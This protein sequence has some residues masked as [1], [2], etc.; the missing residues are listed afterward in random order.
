MHDFEAISVDVRET[1]LFARR[2]GEGPPLLLLHGFPQTHLMWRLVAP[3]L[4]RQF[5]V[6]CADLRGYGASG[7]PDSDGSHGPYAK[8]AMARD[9]VVLME[10]LGFVSFAVAG[11]DRGGR[12]AYRLAL[13]HPGRVTR[14]ALLDVL[15]TSTVWE[16]ADARF[17]LA[18]WPWSM[19]AQPMPLPE[20]L[21]QSAAEAIVDTALDGWGPTSDAF[22][23]AVRAAYALPL[24]DPSHAHAICEEYRAAATLDQK[25]DADDRS[26]GRR[27]ES[28][29]LIL[30]SKGD[31][32][33]TW[34]ADAGGPLSLWRS[35][36][37]DVRGQAI[38]GGH[39]FPETRP[40]E[41]VRAL[42]GF[43]GAAGGG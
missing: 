4:A 7:C 6:V 32:L 36:G 12:V 35:W 8:R 28:P 19:L 41:T 21:L 18:Y 42:A 25:H 24:R 16:H 10:R 17:A 5:T 29:V 33:D 22:T 40:D 38:D 9:L 23:P 34:Y 2:A 20:R 14:L 27:I 15:P 37:S 11:H 26:A 39:F 3:A 43:F 30:W 31:A 1:H 13:D